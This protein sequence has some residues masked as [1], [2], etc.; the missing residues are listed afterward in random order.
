MINPS[1]GV[2][3]TYKAAPSI[4][5]ISVFTPDHTK[6]TCGKVL[7]RIIIYLCEKVYG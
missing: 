7:E 6:N 4:A 3:L 5:N 1:F 2:Y